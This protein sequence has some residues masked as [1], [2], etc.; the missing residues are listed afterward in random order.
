MISGSL[1]CKQ[2]KQRLPRPAGSQSETA[3]KSAS[4]HFG[5]NQPGHAPHEKPLN[6][7]SRVTPEPIRRVNLSQ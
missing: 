1:I 3:F 2:T 7:K 5:E 6:D 4:H